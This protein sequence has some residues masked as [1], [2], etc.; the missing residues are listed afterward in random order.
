MRT[1]NPKKRASL[2]AHAHRALATLR[3]GRF[4]KCDSAVLTPRGPGKL[5]LFVRLKV[6]KSVSARLT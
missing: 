3:L 4:Q 1:S 5:N 2:S 6:R